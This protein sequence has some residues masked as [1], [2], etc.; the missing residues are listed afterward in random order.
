MNT[1]VLKAGFEKGSNRYHLVKRLKKDTADQFVVGM[2]RREEQRRVFWTTHRNLSI[3]FE[4]WEL[5][6]LE[7]GFARPKQESDDDSVSVGSVIFYDGACDRIVNFDET[8]GSL[9]NTSRNRGGR[10]L[11][12]F[13]AACVQGGATIASKSGYSAT[14][15]CGSAASG[16]PLPPHFQLKSEAAAE[17]Q[18]LD[19]DHIANSCDILGKFGFS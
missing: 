17:R 3:W 9:D 18:K 7:F 1:C 15:I 19:I 8:A 10:P 4:Q 14:I 2:A 11:N 5:S 13:Y 16:D 6:L 12:I